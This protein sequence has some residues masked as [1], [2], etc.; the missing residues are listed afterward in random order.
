MITEMLAKR[1]GRMTNMHNDGHGNLRMEFQVPTTRP[2]RF[3]QR[4]PDRHPRRGRHEHAFPGLRALG[5]RDPPPAAVRWW[6]P[7]KV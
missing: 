3:P 5:G 7:P 6:L 2:H 1:L 4:L